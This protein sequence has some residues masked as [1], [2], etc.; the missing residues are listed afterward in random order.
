M[1]PKQPSPNTSKN[2]IREPS[3]F[4]THWNCVSAVTPLH[5]SRSIVATNVR[6]FHTSQT[7]WFVSLV[8]HCWSIF[9]AFDGFPQINN[10]AYKSV[11][12]PSNHSQLH[13][14]QN[15]DSITVTHLSLLF[16]WTA[17]F[18]TDRHTI[19]GSV[20]LLF[21]SRMKICKHHRTFVNLKSL[22]TCVNVKKMQLKVLSWSTGC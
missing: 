2:R 6:P 19:K 21:I 1:K 9:H 12:L 15:L 5:C 16:V 10:I 8:W 14:M 11:Q 4:V 18:H 3:M 22:D 13:C 20:E 7:N 17:D